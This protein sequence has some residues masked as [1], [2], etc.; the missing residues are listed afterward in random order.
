[1]S[2]VYLEAYLLMMMAFLEEIRK[3][4]EPV[5]RAGIWA[6]NTNWDLLNLL[7]TKLECQRL[8][9]NDW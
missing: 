1:M 7:N 8:N 9:L 4:L 2:F 5:R 3:T 6:G